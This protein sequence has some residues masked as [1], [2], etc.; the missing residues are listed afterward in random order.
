MSSARPLA[1]AALAALVLAAPAGAAAKPGDRIVGGSATTIQ[2]WPW[3]VAVA[4]APSYGGGAFDRQICG[5][6]LIEPKLVVTAAHCVYT[7]TD[8]NNALCLPTD[9]FDYPP[10]DY[11]VIAGRTTL[12]GSGGSEIGVKEIYYFD[13]GP[14]GP[15]AEAQTTGDGQGLYTC[16][17]SEWDAVVLE[18]ASA[19]GPPAQPIKI[20]GP[21]EGELW[22]PGREA[23]VTGWGRPG[24]TWMSLRTPRRRTTFIT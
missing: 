2:E 23:F 17:T 13:A 18:L 4:L 10:S 15:R 5:G 1:L 21:S 14:S 7:F 12:T 11:S 19:P 24:S 8:P 9:G 3:Q 16:G 6:S 20:A 22:Q